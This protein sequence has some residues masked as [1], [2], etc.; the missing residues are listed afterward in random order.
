MSTSDAITFL[1]LRLNSEGIASK[2]KF[3]LHKTRLRSI[4]PQMTELGERF[5]R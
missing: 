4:V 1:P 3:E 2:A 5:I